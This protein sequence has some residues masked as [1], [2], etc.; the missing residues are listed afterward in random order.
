MTRM[1]LTDG[2]WA[3]IEPHGLGKKSDPG[4]TGGD[5]RLF[6]EAVLWIARACAPSLR[7]TQGAMR[8]RTGP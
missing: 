6:M 2:Q 8:S 5:G 1:I 7:V 3:L 4:R